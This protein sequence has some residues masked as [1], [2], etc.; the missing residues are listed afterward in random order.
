[1]CSYFTSTAIAEQWCG[2]ASE[3][4]KQL[5][6]SISKSE[7]FN[8]DRSISFLPP[9]VGLDIEDKGI[10]IRVGL[11]VLCE[12]KAIQRNFY[13]HSLGSAELRQSADDCG[14]VDQPS[15][16]VEGVRVSAELAREGGTIV[17]EAPEVLA[18]DC[19]VLLTLNL[20]SSVLRAKVCDSWGFVVQV[21]VI[22]FIEADFSDFV[23]VHTVFAEVDQGFSLRLG[24]RSQALDL[25]HLD[26]E[27]S[28]NAKDFTVCFIDE[29]GCEVEY[30]EHV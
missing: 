21:D 9:V 5:L 6:S 22:S 24:R 13:S 26:V 15:L 28:C 19:N 27:A 10:E 17:V 30:V 11:A 8:A 4:A 20:D 25:S 18:V 12:V 29:L 3:P 14:G 16:G 7:A 23:E 1:M 2:C